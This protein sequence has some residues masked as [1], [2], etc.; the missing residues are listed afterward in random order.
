ML[1]WMKR[2]PAR[3]VAAGAVLLG[4][5]GAVTGQVKVQAIADVL[6]ALAPILGG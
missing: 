6:A 4:G 1:K 3:A 2:N 5:V